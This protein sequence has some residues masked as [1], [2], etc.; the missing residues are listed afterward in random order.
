LSTDGVIMIIAFSFLAGLQLLVVSIIF[1][2]EL[3]KR[4]MRQ[5]LGVPYL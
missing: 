3:A 2:D 5:R 1:R 4:R